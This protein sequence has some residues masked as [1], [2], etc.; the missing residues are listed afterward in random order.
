MS[1]RSAKRP[2][3]E[4]M[5]DVPLA[6]RARL[7]RSERIRKLVYELRN[8]QTFNDLFQ[9]DR[10]LGDSV[11]IDAYWK[12]FEKHLTDEQTVVD[13]G[14]GTGVLAMFAAKHAKRVHAIEHGPVIETAA[15]IA[16]DNGFTNIEFHHMNSQRFE[17]PEKADAIIHEQLGD[18]LFDEKVVE[19]MA[20]LRD[21][22]LK[23]GGRIYPSK[24][25]LYIEPVQLREDMRAP[26]AWQQRL[27]GIDFSRLEEEAVM[28][29]SYL[30]RLFRPFPFGRYLCDRE[31]VVSIDLETARAE[32]LP[33]RISYVRKA[34]GEGFFDGFCVYF[35]AAF[36]DEIQFTTAP[37]A[38]ATNW[39]TP[40]LRVSERKVKP[41]DE[42][43]L[44]LETEDLASPSTWTWN[45]ADA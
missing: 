4:R 26:F 11:R 39:A 33:K 14:T 42:I 9:H 15:A 5:L 40:L 16:A 19:N 28:S 30:Y 21:R 36:D 32:D 43:R 37:D 1:P 38:P 41:G 23:P 44:E 35:D 12:A 17:L 6:V 7:A 13:L 10:M 20:D 27:H 3:S 24:L 25:H 29:H 2:M 18:A 45:W 22:V 8:R 31:P 34:S